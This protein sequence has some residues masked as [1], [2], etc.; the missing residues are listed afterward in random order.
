M[1]LGSNLDVVRRELHLLSVDIERVR[2]VLVER[3]PDLT[4]VDVLQQC[5][6]AGRE[7]SEARSERAEVRH[8]AVGQQSFERID[9]LEL[10]HVQLVLDLLRDVVA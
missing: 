5:L 1:L 9:D 2:A 6:H 10:L 4:A 3:V 7:L 8:D